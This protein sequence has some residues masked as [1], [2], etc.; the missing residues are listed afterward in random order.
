MIYIFL[1]V[2]TLTTF[3]QV[4]HCDFITYD[5]TDYVTENSHILNGITGNG[6]RWAFMTGH[7]SNWHPLTWISHMLDVQL[8]GLNPQGHHLTNLFFHIANTLLLF[9]VLRRM[10]KTVWQSAFVA[11]LFALHPL[12]V[13]SVAWVA[14]RK[15]V[16]SAFF[17]MTTMGAYCLYVERPGTRRYLLVLFLFV[18]GLMAKPMLV[19]LPLIL[20]LL[21]YWPLQRYQKG[22]SDQGIVIN[23]LL[24]D[25][26]K[27]K[28]RKKNGITITDEVKTE[29]SPGFNYP[30]AQVRKLFWEKIPLFAIAALSS[31]VTYIV[32]Q[33]GGAVKSIQAYSLPVRL[34]NAFVS[35][36]AY[37]GKMIWPD[38]LAVFYPHPGLWQRWQVSGAVLI[39]VAITFLVIRE[40]KRFPYLIVGWLWYVG[41]LVPVIGIVQ[42]G[43]QT[44]ADRYTYIP[45]IGL[46]IMAAWI[47]PELLKKWRYRE[48]VLIASSVLILACFSMVTWK[49]VGYWHNSFTLFDHALDVTK[50]NSVAYNNLGDAFY[51]LG[52][53]KQSI[54]NY[55]KSIEIASNDA[56]SYNNRGFSYAAIGNQNQAI[57]DY[58]RAIEIDPDIPEVYYNRGNAN[59]VLGKQNQAIVDYD[60][61]IKINPEYAEAYS[62]RG[63]E[64]KTVGNLKQAIVDYDR[65]IEINSE[66]AGAYFNRA[67]AYAALGN[68][69][70]AS[71]DYKRAVEIDS[72][73]ALSS[74]P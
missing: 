24:S 51:R 62:N 26:R 46:F 71:A 72:R 31:I 67:N 13:E 54:L 11:A 44:R 68:Q 69:K 3:W 33:R 59:A 70:Q 27:G 50:N 21:D 65:A 66:L 61:A 38:N 4:N 45:L 36:V 30:W 7:S 34:Q 5:D 55:S 37:F 25:K 49:Q 73:F 32:Q 52:N 2:A 14:E 23:P 15:D 28:S 48:K 39:L 41:T 22:R 53:P 9:F 6:I 47:V 8:F 40:A 1:T 74:Y 56:H 57:V 64:Y 58:D 43:E 10:S 12:H 29:D 17:W 42:V 35:Y 16:L 18:L 63:I 19:T 60:R 20:L